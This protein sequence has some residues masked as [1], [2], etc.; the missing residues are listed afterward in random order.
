MVVYLSWGERLLR[1][2]SNWRHT[3]AVTLPILSESNKIKYISSFLSTIFGCIFHMCVV[4]DTEFGAH[5]WKM[6]HW[7]F[8]HE[9]Y[10]YSKYFTLLD[11]TA[12]YDLLR[13]REA[14]Y[15]HSTSFISKST[16]LQKRKKQ[17]QK[18]QLCTCILLLYQHFFAITARPPRENAC[19]FTFYSEDVNK[20]RRTFFLYEF[21][22]IWQNK[23]LVIIVKKFEKNA[24]RLLTKKR[25]FCRSRCLKVPTGSLHDCDHVVSFRQTR[26]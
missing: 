9:K 7:R 8:K 18:E 16:T 12:R 1:A 14:Q 2:R 26:K 22:Y 21:A 20:R 3:I 17:N 6:S 5:N 19:N 4:L 10:N 15:G 24:N 23:R 25:R 13:I 11:T